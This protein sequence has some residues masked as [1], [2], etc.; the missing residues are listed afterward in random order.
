MGWGG[1]LECFKETLGIGG[2]NLFEAVLN[3]AVL[4]KDYCAVL[5]AFFVICTEIQN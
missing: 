1:G 3:N 4:F 2:H 5:I